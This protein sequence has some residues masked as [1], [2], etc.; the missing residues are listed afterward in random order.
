MA[1]R[2]HLCNCNLNIF[3]CLNCL[4]DSFSLPSVSFRYWSLN[5]LKPQRAWLY[6]YHEVVAKK[7]LKPTQF[8]LDYISILE[9]LIQ[10]QDIGEDFDIF[11]RGATTIVIQTADI[12]SD[13]SLT[14]YEIW[15]GFFN[16]YD[17][18]S[19]HNL[20]A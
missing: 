16:L 18:F 1:I 17:E 12:S 15:N 6:F 3:L 11:C 5:S 8:K 7:E 14:T 13:N 10:G 4:F 19:S 9:Q 20:V 2:L